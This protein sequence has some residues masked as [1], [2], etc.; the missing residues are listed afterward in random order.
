MSTVNANIRLGYQD[1][2]WFTTNA[3]LVL[4]SGQIV[5]R[6]TDAKYKIGDGVTALSALTFYGGI[7]SSGL[8]IGTSTITSGTNTR[9]LYNNNGVVG[10][11][12]VTGTGTTAVLSTSPT[13]T[14]DITTP[15]IIASDLLIYNSATEYYN[16]KTISANFGGLY[17]NTG[18]PSST[19]YTFAGDGAYAVVNA[20]TLSV[21]FRSANTTWAQGTSLLSN[22]SGGQ[23]SLTALTSLN[24]TANSQVQK[25]ISNGASTQ[26]ASGTTA[27]Q[28][29][30]VFTSPTYSGVA[31]TTLTIAANTVS[32]FPITST[33]MSITTSAAFYNPTRT[34]T[35]ATTTAYGGLFNAPS[36]AT[37]NW[38][39]GAIGAV[40]STIGYGVGA[41]PSSSRPV[42]ASATVAGEYSYFITNLSSGV[43]AQ[44]AI[45]FGNNNS[46]ATIGLAGTGATSGNGLYARAINFNNN[47]VGGFSFWSRTNA[48]SGAWNGFRFTGS[49]HTGQTASTAINGVL[50]TLGSRQWA[51]GAITTQ[52]EFELTSPTYS[53]VGASTIT[54]AAT[55]AANQPTAGTNATFTN[56]AAIASYGNIFIGDTSSVPA[57]NP[58]SGG[59]LYVEAGALKYRGSSGTVTTLGTA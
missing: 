6:S 36:G 58:T 59:I 21:L 16:F 45:R 39:I 57:N 48:T 22:T 2:A 52:K 1:A 55:F 32:D 34:L 17:F 7:S 28:Y 9:V 33:N 41:T 53:F 38:A 27:T 40:T 56:R 24:N 14:T 11:Y 42:N 5:Y 29:E 10:E 51:T 8:T 30:N 23:F 37:N 49:D 44:A 35:S 3:A 20:P 47:E 26:W 31:A 54:L 12:A 19:N 43:S 18:S 25:F 4:L 13:F 15:K 50:F 46:E